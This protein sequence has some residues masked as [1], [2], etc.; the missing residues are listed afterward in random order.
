MTAS[1]REAPRMSGVRGRQGPRREQQ[2]G[3]EWWAREIDNRGRVLTVGAGR[4]AA[5]ANHQEGRLLEGA[6]PAV[7]A[8]TEAIQLARERLCGNACAGDTEGIRRIACRQ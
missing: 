6:Q 7:L 3:R 2:D 4:E 5:A 1:L 8:A